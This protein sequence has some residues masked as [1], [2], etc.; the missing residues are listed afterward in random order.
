[1]PRRKGIEFY[2]RT[3]SCGPDPIVVYASTAEAWCPCGAM[4]RER[5][6]AAELPTNPR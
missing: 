5:P 4:V 6:V 1:M 3:G 2:C